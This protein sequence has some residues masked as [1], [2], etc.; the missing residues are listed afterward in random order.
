VTFTCVGHIGISVS[1]RITFEVDGDNDL[2]GGRRRVRTQLFQN[3]NINGPNNLWFLPILPRCSISASLGS[4]DSTRT[5]LV[6]SFTPVVPVEMHR[7]LLDVY[8][9]QP[10]FANTDMAKRWH[11]LGFVVQRPS[12]GPEPIF[13][14]TQRGDLYKDTYY[15]AKPMPTEKQRG[16][17]HAFSSRLYK[18][19]TYG[20]GITLPKPDSGNHPITTVKSLQEHLQT[21]MAV[22]LSTIPLY[23]FAMYSVTTPA[24]YVNDP[25]YYDPITGAVR[26]MSS[27]RCICSC[28]LWCLV[29]CFR[30]RSGRDASS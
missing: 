13:V 27:F 9:D 17:L 3:L 26:G 22:E 6:S 14:E 23:L 25:R 12:E 5:T 29:L 19:P 24:A 4:A 30:S 21:A 15:S 11:L 10:L 20:H 1:L 18:G 7:L 28:S 8:S 16:D 2:V